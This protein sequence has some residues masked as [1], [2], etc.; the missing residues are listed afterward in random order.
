MKL[1]FVYM[2]T[3]DKGQAREIGRK[4]VEERLAACANIIDGMNTIYWWQGAVCEDTEAILIVKTRE[5]LFEK[6]IKR[7]KEL[8]TYSVPCIISLPIENGNPSY[9]QWLEDETM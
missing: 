3:K 6:L 2:T 4:L 1:I 8:H 5:S 7:V 9:L